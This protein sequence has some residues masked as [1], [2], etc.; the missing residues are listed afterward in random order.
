[1]FKLTIVRSI[2]KCKYEL[3]LILVILF[4]LIVTIIT[5]YFSEISTKRELT[6]L[7][8]DFQKY[9]QEIVFEP[10]ISQLKNGLNHFQRISYEFMSY[11]ANYFYLPVFFLPI[12]IVNILKNEKSKDLLILFISLFLS[13]IIASFYMERGHTYPTRGISLLSYTYLLLIHPF[14]RKNMTITLAVNSVIIFMIIIYTIHLLPFVTDSTLYLKDNNLTLKSLTEVE[15]KN[16]KWRYED[17]KERIRI[18]INETRECIRIRINKQPSHVYLTFFD[19]RYFDDYEI[20]YNYYWNDTSLLLSFSLPFKDI[21]NNF[22]SELIFYL[23]SKNAQFQNKNFTNCIEIK[24]FEMENKPT[25]LENFMNRK[26]FNFD[27]HPLFHENFDWRSLANFIYNS[28]KEKEIINYIEFYVSLPSP[29]ILYLS[30][31]NMTEV[32]S[33]NDLHKNVLY[34]FEI[35][36]TSLLLCEKKGWYGERWFVLDNMRYWWQLREN[37]KKMLEEKC[38]KMFFP[39]FLIYRCVQYCI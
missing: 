34:P 27:I 39:K 21:K 24:N 33:F 1:M 16:I 26:I 20:P 17:C 5:T 2:K 19:I 13:I 22:T 12:A 18:K 29:L 14:K 30:K 11:L 3:M 38:E 6:N 37:E 8:L 25:S 15:Y 35:N 10:L 28:I 7:Y 31:H 36:V 9:L 23:S 4:I 32:I